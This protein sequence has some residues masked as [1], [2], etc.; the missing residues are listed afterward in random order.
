MVRTKNITPSGGGDD[1]DPPRPF[2]Q[3]K[4]K[5]VYLEQQEGREKRRLDRAARAALVAA[6]TADQAEQGGQLRISSNQI[7][8][9]VRCLAPPLLTHSFRPSLHSTSHFVSSCR[10][11]AVHHTHFV[12]HLHHSSFHCSRSRLRSAYSSTSL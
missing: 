9:R 6:A 8:Y 11:R 1:E 12:D 5:T 3:V 4:G 7:A 10:S 2:R